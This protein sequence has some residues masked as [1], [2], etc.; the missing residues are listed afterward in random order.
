[1]RHTPTRET[2]LAKMLSK[3]FEDFTR[4]LIKTR[5][6]KQRGVTKRNI[7]LSGSG[8]RKTRKHFQNKFKKNTSQQKSFV[9][10]ET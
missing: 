1:M 3:L 4:S 2:H 6:L 9:M 8:V 10:P 5:F 7:S